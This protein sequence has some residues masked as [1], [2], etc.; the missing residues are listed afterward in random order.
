MYYV[1]EFGGV[2]WSNGFF[3]AYGGQMQKVIEN[4]GDKWKIRW[5]GGE[6]FLQGDGRRQRVRA[7]IWRFKDK[8]VGDEQEI[9]KYESNQV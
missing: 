2:T 4:K 8:R 3:L 6:E 5:K 7:K 1:P 9:W